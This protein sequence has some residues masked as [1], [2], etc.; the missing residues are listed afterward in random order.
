MY[1]LYNSL[2]TVGGTLHSTITPAGAT[3]LAEAFKLNP[4]IKEVYLGLNKITTAR[5]TALAEAFKV[6]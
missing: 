6:S 3:A 5:A 4:N 2:Y 1:I